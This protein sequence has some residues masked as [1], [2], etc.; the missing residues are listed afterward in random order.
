MLIRFQP[1]IA[2]T[3]KIGQ[4]L[5]AEVLARLLEQFIRR[6]PRR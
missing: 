2:V 4:F 1:L 5:F 3:A 6:M